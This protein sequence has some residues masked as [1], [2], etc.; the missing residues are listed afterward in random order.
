MRFRAN[1]ALMPLEEAVLCAECQHISDARGEA[2]PRCQSRSLLNLARVLN[3]PEQRRCSEH[4]Q[5]GKSRGGGRGAVDAARPLDGKESAMPDGML[6]T[7][8]GEANVI[9]TSAPGVAR[10]EPTCGSMAT[11]PCESRG[12]LCSR[13]LQWKTCIWPDHIAARAR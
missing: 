2:C 4:E 8:Q 5:H 12:P 9:A 13:C 10:S 6:M 7:K 3:R 11:M 1:G